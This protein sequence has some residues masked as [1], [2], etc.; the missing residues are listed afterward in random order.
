M[1]EQASGES[2]HN[3]QTGSHCA[4]HYGFLSHRRKKAWR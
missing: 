1:S 2:Q 4:T 3:E